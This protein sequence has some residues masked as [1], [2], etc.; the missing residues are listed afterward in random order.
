MRKIS[1]P[2]FFLVI[3]SICCFMVLWEWQRQAIPHYK[4]KSK[5]KIQFVVQQTLQMSWAQGVQSCQEIHKSSW[6]LEVMDM[7]L[8]LLA[9]CVHRCSVSTNPS[10]QC[11]VTVASL[12]GWGTNSKLALPD[13]LIFLLLEELQRSG[14]TLG[15]CQSAP[16][17][18]FSGE[19]LLSAS[20]LT[21]GFQWQ[22]GIVFKGPQYWAISHYLPWW[23][24][25]QEDPED[26]IAFNLHL[27]LC[28]HANLICAMGWET[29][30][31]VW[32]WWLD[33]NTKLQPWSNEVLGHA[34]SINRSTPFQYN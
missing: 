18:L 34:Q 9:S 19:W 27:S 6:T 33:L 31:V 17:S 14:S 32:W 8:L 20:G 22:C 28:V 10:S 29:C 7:C 4:I 24:F 13:Y 26:L 15:L 5:K 21:I 11:Q 23:P 2:S 16:L 1:R 3:N 25:V 30:R 12:R